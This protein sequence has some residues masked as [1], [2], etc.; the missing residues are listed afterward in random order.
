MRN[1]KIYLMLLVFFVVSCKKD[2]DDALNSTQESGKYSEVIKQVREKVAQKLNSTTSNREY[3][4]P[5]E[6][7]ENIY[8]YFGFK[9][10]EILD[11]VMGHPNYV[12]GNL[13][14]I[15]NIID[16]YS[17]D[18]SLNMITK[19]QGITAVSEIAENIDAGITDFDYVVESFESDEET[20]FNSFFDDM[21]NV[22]QED[23]DAILITSKAYEEAIMEYSFTDPDAEARLLKT[24]AVYRYSSK[25]WIDA[26]STVER[27]NAYDAIFV[28]Y[29]ILEGWGSC[30]G[31]CYNFG[32]WMSAIMGL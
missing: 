5:V 19:L 4:E 15:Y 6:Y 18:S 12:T 13:D 29:C 8:D 7:E 21:N 23:L 10:N 3:T 30:A 11:Y 31:D 22:E 25:Y 17:R 14:S 32:A 28:Y 16:E 2:V 27:P 24:M 20:F 9:H 26:G 1:L